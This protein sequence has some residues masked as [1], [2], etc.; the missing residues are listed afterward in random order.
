MKN[1]VYLS[2]AKIIDDDLEIYSCWAI[3]GVKNVFKYRRWFGCAWAQ[4][5]SMGFYSDG[6]NFGRNKT[7]RR[8]NRVLALLFMHWISQG[9][10]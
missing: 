7:E 4:S 10:I 2:A 3:D 8:N 5:G 6:S 9:D 1:D